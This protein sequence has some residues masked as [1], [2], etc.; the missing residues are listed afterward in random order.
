MPHYRITVY[1]QL[2]NKDVLVEDEDDDLI[3]TEAE[4]YIQDLFKGS[5]KSIVISKIT[6]K[7][8]MRD[9]L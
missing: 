8:G 1:D 3:L 9:D 7:A 5:L 2:G 6:G 4:T